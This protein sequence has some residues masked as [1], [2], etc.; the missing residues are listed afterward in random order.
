MTM[1]DRN[2]GV[3]QNSND[4]VQVKEPSSQNRVIGIIITIVFV[5]VLLI[6]LSISSG[7]FIFY[8]FSTINII[9]IYIYN[10][11]DKIQL[12]TVSVVY[13]SS[14]YPLFQL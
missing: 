6:I 9:N 7:G 8:S 5:I 3:A 11:Y 14:T 13:T 4:L 12:Y 10:T 2:Y 1:D